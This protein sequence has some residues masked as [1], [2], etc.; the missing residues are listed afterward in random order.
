MCVRACVCARARPRVWSVSAYNIAGHICC[1]IYRLISLWLPSGL[2]GEVPLE[3]AG[4]ARL[5]PGVGRGEA[6]RVPANSWRGRDLGEG[7]WEAHALP[8]ASRGKGPRRGRRV[9]ARPG[10]LPAGS[11][12]RGRPLPSVARRAV[13]P[14]GRLS[15]SSAS[16]SE[17]R[18]SGTRALFIPAARLWALS[19]P[20]A[21]PG[22]GGERGL[23]R[24][25]VPP[26]P[27][28]A[29]VPPRP[30]EQPR[31]EARRSRWASPRA[32]L[33]NASAVCAGAGGRRREA[34]PPRLTLDRSLRQK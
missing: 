29:P 2:P 8:P 22:G 16:A 13:P 11:E 4:A 18:E 7:P 34:P 24:A 25:E 31:R 21:L 12:E 1:K 32:G 23:C 30:A 28:P 10:L 26:L 27:A 3:G 33:A 17:R 19:P 14:S 9:R 15:L 6:S 20:P 5:C